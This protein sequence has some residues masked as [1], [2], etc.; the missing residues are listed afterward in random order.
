M[1]AIG[2]PGQE[3]KHGDLRHHGRESHR[4]YEKEEHLVSGPGLEPAESVGGDDEGY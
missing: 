1:I 3:E 4:P 2:Q